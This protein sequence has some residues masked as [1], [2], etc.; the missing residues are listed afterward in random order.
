MPRNT[1]RSKI[2]H[3]TLKTFTK[4]ML[5]ISLSIAGISHANAY[6]SVTFFGDSL[7]DGGYF[8]PLTQGAFWA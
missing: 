5:A 8:S 6:D 1:S 3:T 2:S 4:S 7:T